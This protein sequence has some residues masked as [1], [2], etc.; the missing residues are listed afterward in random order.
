M[1]LSGWA[2]VV[3]VIPPGAKKLELEEALRYHT[4]WTTHDRDQVRAALEAEYPGHRRGDVLFDDFVSQDHWPVALYWYVPP[5]GGYVAGHTSAKSAMSRARVNAL[6][7]ELGVKGPT[8]FGD[9]V[10]ANAVYL[11]AGYAILRA[12]TD[13]PL[14][15]DLSAARSNSRSGRIAG[16][17]T[18][19]VCP[20]CFLV[21]AGECP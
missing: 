6:S 17:R 7:R 20:D 18:A 21:H 9:P 5:S 2:D 10:P 15:M 8:Y 13:D 14:R 4:A 1:L 3:A 12:D 11:H 16:A 19:P